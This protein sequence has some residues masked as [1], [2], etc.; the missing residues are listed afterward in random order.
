M[1]SSL[2]H[3]NVVPL[4]G[5]C[6]RPL[7]LVVALAPL[8]DLSALLQNYKRSGAK[9]HL[10]VLQE[11]IAQVRLFSFQGPCRSANFVFNG[12]QHFVFNAMACRIF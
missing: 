9:L 11:T 3:P 6:P 12:M 2:Q 4:V 5:V 10:T 1:L 7:A 8:G